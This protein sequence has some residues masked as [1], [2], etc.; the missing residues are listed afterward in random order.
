[1]NADQVGR[2]IAGLSDTAPDFA[3]YLIEFPFG[4]ILHDSGAIDIGSS[5]RTL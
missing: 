5:V 2:I 4:D 1:V 3:I